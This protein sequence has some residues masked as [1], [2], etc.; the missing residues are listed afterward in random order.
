M[1]TEIIPAIAFSVF[2]II[3][4]IKMICCSYD[5]KYDTQKEIDAMTKKINKGENNKSI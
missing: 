4:V 1:K 3:F 5:E 2:S